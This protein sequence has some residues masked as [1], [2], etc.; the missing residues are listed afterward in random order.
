MP[1]D[2]QHEAAPKGFFSRFEIRPGEHKPHRTRNGAIG[3]LL[4]AFVL[5][6]G[7]SRHV[8]FWPKGGTIV[9]AAFQNAANVRSGTD[10]RIRGVNVGKV[11]DIVP[12]ANQAL[13]KMRIDSGK[14]K[15]LR[16]DAGATIY[17]RTL[18]GRNMYIELD[19]GSAPSKLGSATIPKTRTA[20]QV[21]LDQALT[22][23]DAGARKGFQTFLHTFRQGFGDGS[24]VHSTLNTLAPAARRISAGVGAL[25]GTSPGDLPAIVA[26]TSKV[27]AQLDSD[28]AALG[29]LIDGAEV[30]LGV[31]AARKAELAATLV[32]APGAM[33]LATTE[34]A[35]LT[36]TLDRLDPL[37]ARL[38]PGVRKL[39][40]A[41]D[42]IDPALQD[43][44]PLLTQ[45]K[46]FTTDLQP[47]VRRLRSAAISGSP[48][49]TALGPALDRANSKILPYLDSKDSHTGRKVYEL[50]GPTFSSLDSLAASY[51]DKGHDVSFQVGSGLRLLGG[52][53]PCEALLTDPSKAASVNCENFNNALSGLFGKPAGATRVSTGSIVQPAASL[54]SATSAA[55]GAASGAVNSV[56]KL[57]G[58]TLGGKGGSR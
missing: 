55:G 29:G 7:Y 6:S 16:S 37:A 28:E 22:S 1:L 34:M 17:W 3:L 48:A 4:V 43:L 38:R 14:V 9:D 47:A 20:S 41:V 30:T 15:L 27:T 52:V 58:T 54:S 56:L 46:P 21:E 32:K 36:T 45:L 53:I 8:L 24:A 57:V 12:G 44:R 50:L 2:I 13:V 39:P 10:V 51:D 19:P 35:S 40:A 26:N 42:A 23:L 11:D 5:I 33:A 18:L 25:S 49:F 31:T